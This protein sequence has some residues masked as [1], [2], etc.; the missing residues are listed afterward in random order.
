M[1]GA[2]VWDRCWA[3]A[4][5]GHA[6]PRD[7]RRSAIMTHVTRFYYFNG[8]PR[9][10]AAH[11]TRILI[12]R[13]RASDPSFRPVPPSRPPSSSARLFH[14]LGR[15]RLGAANSSEDEI[16]RATISL[17]RPRTEIRGATGRTDFTPENKIFAAIANRSLLK[18]VPRCPN[19]K[20]LNY[21]ETGL[22]LRP[23]HKQ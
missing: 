7:H 4:G 11:A 10:A 15:A 3:G 20:F 12:G 1:R 6:P 5:P 22:L 2:R 19:Y 18:I 14:P 13:F 9:R 17:D 23:M 16:F 21:S 8:P